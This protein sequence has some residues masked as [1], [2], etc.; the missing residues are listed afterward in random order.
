MPSDS[1]VSNGE[2]DIAHTHYRRGSGYY[3]GSYEMEGSFLSQQL[4][5]I[6]ETICDVRS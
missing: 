4:I 2:G 6:V 3:V 5:H 1:I